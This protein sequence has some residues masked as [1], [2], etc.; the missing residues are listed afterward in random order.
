MKNGQVT[1]FCVLAIVGGI[2]WWSFP[3]ETG[4]AG[5]TLAYG[6]FL[7]G[8]IGV[9]PWWAGLALAAVPV[10]ILIYQF[11]GSKFGPIGLFFSFGYIALTAAFSCFLAMLARS[12]EF[13]H[14]MSRVI[15]GS[16]RLLIMASF[17][18]LPASGFAQTYYYPYRY[19]V[20]Y[21]TYYYA[22]HI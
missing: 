3:G 18:L 8:L 16:K 11:E 12:S 19:T 7:A 2:F 9:K 4:E 15:F 6:V 1:G 14:H 5:D 10:C 17:L 13:R 21:P 22:D 20:A